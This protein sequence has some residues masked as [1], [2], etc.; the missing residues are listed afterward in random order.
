MRTLSDTVDTVLLGCI[1][2]TYSMPVDS[3]PQVGDLVG[4]M[5]DL[6]VIVSYPIGALISLGAYHGISPASFKVR[7][8]I[9]VVEE[10]TKRLQIP[11]RGDLLQLDESSGRLVWNAYRINANF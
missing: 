4:H 10:L 8:G 6:I 1:Q 9:R 11:I 2:L 3:G 5:H 7:T